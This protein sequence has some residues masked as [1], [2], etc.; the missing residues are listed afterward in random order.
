M[1]IQY[2][3]IPWRQ[4]VPLPPLTRDKKSTEHEI[5]GGLSQFSPDENGTV[6]LPSAAAADPAAALPPTKRSSPLPLVSQ[7]DDYQWLILL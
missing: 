7:D 4:P 5:A 6:S 2:Q 3:H 1:M